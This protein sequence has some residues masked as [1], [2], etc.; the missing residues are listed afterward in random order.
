MM[1]LVSQ[2]R[3]SASRII[4]LDSELDHTS[5]GVHYM[6]LRI[7]EHTDTDCLMVTIIHCMERKRGSKPRGNGVGGEATSEGPTVETRW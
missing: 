3:H 1:Q 7:L 6:L 5:T 2:P 4:V